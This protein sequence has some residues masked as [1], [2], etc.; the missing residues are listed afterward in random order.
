MKKKSTPVKFPRET[1]FEVLDLLPGVPDTEFPDYLVISDEIYDKRRWSITYQLIF[2]FKDKFYKT[3]YSVGAT[4]Q[5]DEGPWQYEGDQID[6]WEV[7]P[8]EKTVIV[9]EE[10]W[11]AVE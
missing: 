5:Q 2:K 9:Y 3:Y 7:K 8:V 1:M 4:E 6:C 10:V 11:D